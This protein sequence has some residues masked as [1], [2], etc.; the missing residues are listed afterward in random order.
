MSTRIHYAWRVPINKL[1]ETFDHVRSQLYDRGEVILRMAINNIT[2]EELNKRKESYR[3]EFSESYMKCEIALEKVKEASKSIERNPMFDVDFVF[4]VWLNGDHAYLI[5]IGEC[6]DLEMP[7]WAE[8]YSYWNSSDKDE[9]VTEEEWDAREAKW[10]EI[11][12][13]EGV[14]SQN[15]RRLC[16][17]IID[18]SAKLGD[19]DFVYEMR[20]RLVNRKKK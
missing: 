6:K 3:F 17:S 20:K 4:N 7:E 12:C 19:F 8:D 14:H 16:H 9:N 15:A 2:E 1:N 5:P 13:G 11:N 10:D 18:L